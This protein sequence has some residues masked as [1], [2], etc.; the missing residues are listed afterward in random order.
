ME[1]RYNTRDGG[2]AHLLGGLGLGLGDAHTH[3]DTSYQS[4]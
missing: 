3:L 4:M 1:P 2:A